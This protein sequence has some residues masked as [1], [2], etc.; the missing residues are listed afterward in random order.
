MGPETLEGS[1]KD[2]Y[3]LMKLIKKLTKAEVTRYLMTNDATFKMLIF[4]L[5]V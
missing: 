2:C 3:I 1:K 4:C 5:F